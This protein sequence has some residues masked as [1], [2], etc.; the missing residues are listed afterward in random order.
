M[1]PENLTRASLN[2]ARL[3]YCEGFLWASESA[4]LEEGFGLCTLR[5][6]SCRSKDGTPG[7]GK[8]LRVVMRGVLIL[9]RYGKNFRLVEGLE[10][11]WTKPCVARL[12]LGSRT[13]PLLVLESSLTQSLVWSTGAHAATYL[14]KVD[15]ECLYDPM[16]L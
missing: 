15:P 12:A 7:T 2:T 1:E 9:A 10:Q 11:D 8:L 16:H 6:A 13:G 4:G 5:R 3:P 14:P